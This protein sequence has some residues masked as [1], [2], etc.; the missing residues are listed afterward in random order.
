MKPLLKPSSHS[1]L[2]R[3]TMRSPSFGLRSRREIPRVHLRERYDH[4]PRYSLL[5][6]YNPLAETSRSNFP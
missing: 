4:P 5:P 6:A 2:Y 3:A 1:K